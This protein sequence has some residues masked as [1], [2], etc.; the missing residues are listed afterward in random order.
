MKLLIGGVAL[1]VVASC[2]SSPT[3]DEVRSRANS[4]QA[5]RDIKPQ[6][7]ERIEPMR[8]SIREHRLSNE[9]R[10]VFVELPES[11]FVTLATVVPGGVATTP[12]HL[13]GV[14]Q[15]IV[16]LM[17]DSSRPDAA[18]SRAEGLGSTVEAAVRLDRAQIT[19]VGLERHLDES[20]EILGDLL[21]P[22]LSEDSVARAKAR[23]ARELTERSSS[24]LLVT[25]DTLRTQM[26]GRAHPLGN[27][28]V[29]APE[30]LE[31][32]EVSQIAG[33]L[34][35]AWV[36]SNL[37]IVV[38]GEYDRESAV[39]ALEEHVG[40][41]PARPRVNEMDEESRRQPLVQPLI[42][43][44]DDPA[45]AQ[46]TIVA[47]HEL[48]C[49]RPAAV[50][51]LMNF[52]YGGSAEARL[53]LNLREQRGITYA[54]R[55]R[56]SRSRAGDHLVVLGRFQLDGV[57]TAVAEIL[58]ELDELSSSEPSADEM[59]R[60][61]N[62]ALLHRGLSFERGPGLASGIAQQ[63]SRGDSLDTVREYEARLLSTQLAEVAEA[64]RECLAP[65]RLMFVVRGPIRTIGEDLEAA[66]IE[67][68]VIE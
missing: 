41:L 14:D 7:P 33:R 40:R 54:V 9:A 1:L 20:L 64:G 22:T 49:S 62:R 48:R 50:V 17:L 37:I 6:L 38:V 57:A 47:G 67:F 15:V 63:L 31:S 39:A 26:F 51:D 12:S 21:R 2:A 52:V 66:G 68:A 45:A 56:I 65:E 32:L 59:A 23:A 46:A 16:E 61:R 36:P 25:L 13:A 27:S 18:V 29:G 43:L 58:R 4:S 55:S 34:A 19:L 28:P 8:R 60:A 24:G 5:W 11:S 53:N 44:V 42:R 3:H 35:T 10:V 30:T